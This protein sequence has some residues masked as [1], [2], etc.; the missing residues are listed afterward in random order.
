[1]KDLS[2]NFWKSTTFLLLFIFSFF[3]GFTGKV[4]LVHYNPYLSIKVAFFI[5]LIIFTVQ[6]PS[7]LFEYFKERQ[8]HEY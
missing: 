5:S 7:L 8:Q 2:N 4:Q 3:S 6:L 1:M